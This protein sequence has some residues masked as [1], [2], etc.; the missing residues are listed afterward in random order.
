MGDTSPAA[1][2]LFRSPAAIRLGRLPQPEPEFTP[3]PY[4]DFENPGKNAEPLPPVPQADP[5]STTKPLTA[6]K[7]LY[8][9]TKPD[10]TRRVLFQAEVCMTEGPLE[11]FLCKTKTKE[12]EAVL[13]TAV[14]PELVHA[15]LIAAGA[16]QGSPVQFVDPKTGDADYHPASGE[17]IRVTVTYTK[18]GKVHTRPAQEWVRDITTEKPMVHDWVF[19]GSRFVKNPD[20][21]DA[22][23]Y[24][25]A[26]NGEIIGISNFPDSMLDLPV[27]VSQDNADLAF[28]ARTVEIPPLLSKVWVALEP[29]GAKKR[30]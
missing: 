2:K 10:G 20:K 22:P 3:P 29:I 15:A 27:A 30:E 23:P 7:S 16:E 14:P 9:E 6:D 19:S 4:P 11:V 28:E 25:T 17:K 26:N 8:L 18:K 1:G 21:P 24:Y 5:K 12:H 13:R